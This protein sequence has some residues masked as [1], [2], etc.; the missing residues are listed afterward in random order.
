L[1]EL[2]PLCWHLTHG[3][4]CFAFHIL[5]CKGLEMM[6]SDKMCTASCTYVHV[7]SLCYLYHLLLTWRVTNVNIQKIL[8]SCTLLSTLHLRVMD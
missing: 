3:I 4:I 8:F 1:G 5:F 6:G 7:Q 2:V